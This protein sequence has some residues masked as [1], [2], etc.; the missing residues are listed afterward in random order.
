MKTRIFQL[1]ALALIFKFTSCQGESK[2]AEESQKEEFCAFSFS[3]EDIEFEWTAYK[4]TGKVGVP[5]SFNIIETNCIDSDDPI[6]VIESITFAM[7]TASV[8]TNNEERNGKVAEHFFTTINT[9]EITGEFASLDQV[10][11][12]AKINVKMNGIS[13]PIEGDYTLENNR[14][15][16]NTTIDVSAWNGLPG[17]TALNEVC[18]DLHKGD[19]LVSKLWSEVDLKLNIKLVSDCD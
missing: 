15:S 19:D 4:T 18:S 8:E 17:I 16:F 10:N 9:P 14:F 3:E 6:E 13:V 1:L 7:K 12:K 11:H 2:T 5:G